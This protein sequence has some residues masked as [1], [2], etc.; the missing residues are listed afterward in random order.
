MHIT[1]IPQGY[2]VKKKHQPLPPTP[3][4]HF[5]FPEP[6]RITNFLWVSW[7]KYP[8]HKSAYMFVVR[9]GQYHA[10]CSASCVLCVKYV[11]VNAQFQWIFLYISLEVERCET[12][13]FIVEMY[14]YLFKKFRAY[15]IRV[16]LVFRFFCSNY[17][18]SFLSLV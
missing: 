4:L 18:I 15:I 9:M 12:Y 5:S 8:I 11:L 2:T 10:H 1:K 14:H 7:K 16:L 3:D 6:I 13:Y 17:C